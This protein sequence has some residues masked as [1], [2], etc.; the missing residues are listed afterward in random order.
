MVSGSGAEKHEGDGCEDYDCDGVGEE[1]VFLAVV[2]ECPF[3]QER[4]TKTYGAACSRENAVCNAAL[5]EEPLVEDG[6][7]V[8]VD[9]DETGAV[10]SSLRD[11]EARYRVG[12]GR[13][14][15]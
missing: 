10:K 4:E 12:V 3:D 15:K 2:L 13:A 8:E 14:N 5:G 7:H 9:E 1:S 6:D 11:N